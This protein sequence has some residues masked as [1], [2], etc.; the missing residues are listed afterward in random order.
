MTS[1]DWFFSVLSCVSP[2]S[3]LVLVLV[4]VHG[5]SNMERVSDSVQP[6]SKTYLPAPRGHSGQHGQRPEWKGQE[7][8]RNRNQ[9]R[10][11][12]CVIGSNKALLGEFGES[13]TVHSSY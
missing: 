11:K 6:C 1:N 10:Y 13:L 3:C 7:C 12:N 9:R 2:Y 8:S 5:P 4:V